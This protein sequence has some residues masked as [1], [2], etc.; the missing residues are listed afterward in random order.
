MLTIE[1]EPVD[2]NSVDRYLV[3]RGVWSRMQQ[4]SESALVG[5]LNVALDGEVTAA[6]GREP[7]SPRAESGEG[8]TAF[9]CGRCGTNLARD[10]ER[11]GHYG[12][13]LQT[14]YGALTGVRVPMLEC[15]VCGGAASI[16]FA[17]LAKHQQLWLD[18]DLEALFGYGREEGLR[19]IADRVG[20]VLGWPVSAGSIQRRVHQL[21]SSLDAWRRERIEDPPDGLMVDGLWFTAVLPTGERFV[22]SAG[23]DRPRMRKAKR[24]AVVVL[25]LWA[26]TGRQ[27]ILD[28][29]IAEGEDEATVVR[30]LNRV[31]ERGVTEA[32]V[33]LIASDGAEGIAAAIGTVYPTVTRQR[34]IVHKLRNVWSH[35][36]DRENRGALMKS[37]AAIYDA[38]DSAEASARMA[39]WVHQWLDTET[40][41]VACLVSDFEATIGY[42]RAPRLPNPHRFRTINPIE[43]GAMRPL[44]KKL[45]HAT[46]FHSITGAEVALF[47]CA[48][49]LNASQR[50]QPWTHAALRLNQ[51]Y[52]DLNP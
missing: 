38:A 4:V 28:F 51:T 3:F 52:L 37:A 14:T 50:G 23:R 12:R 22:D 6:L 31:H 36:R 2:V 47:L 45:D 18:I 8:S 25:G 5:L 19:H 48:Q 24:V 32:H 13:Q 9:A 20:R 43:G 7:R 44:R 16:E 46:A 30:L 39:A 15:R 10:L 21:H 42:L 34:C 41:A 35:V 29:E 17:A 27:E 26:E 40:E 49:R 33:K 11:A 1:I